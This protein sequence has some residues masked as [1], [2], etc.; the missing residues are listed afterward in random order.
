MVNINNISIHFYFFYPSQTDPLNNILTN[1]LLGC[2]NKIDL[3]CKII[4]KLQIFNII[5]NILT[6]EIYF[7]SKLP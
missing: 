1:C 6:I 5:E 2:L 7:D 3:N 4:K